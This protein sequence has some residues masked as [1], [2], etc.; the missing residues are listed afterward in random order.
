M[1]VPRQSSSRLPSC[2]L[3]ALVEADAAARSERGD[4]RVMQCLRCALQANRRLRLWGRTGGASQLRSDQR[5]RAMRMHLKVA[6][7]L[8]LPV[9]ISVLKHHQP[10]RWCDGFATTPCQRRRGAATEA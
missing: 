9:L 4:P 3:T 1:L 8:L 2:G 10:L 6:E 5:Q 7:S